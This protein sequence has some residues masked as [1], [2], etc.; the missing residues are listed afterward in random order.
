LC[1]CHDRA[2]HGGAAAGIT[3]QEPAHALLVTKGDVIP[4]LDRMEASGWVGRLQEGRCNR[5]IP[6]AAVVPA[7][8]KIIARLFA[9]LPADLPATLRR[10]DHTPV[11]PPFLAPE[12]DSAT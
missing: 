7:Q 5:L 1:H 12:V 6:T 8:E 11:P 3:R 10:V 2:P 4:L 9:M